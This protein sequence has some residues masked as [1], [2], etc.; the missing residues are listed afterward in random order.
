MTEIQ[1]DKETKIINISKDLGYGVL[2]I[3]AVF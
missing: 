1:L 2:H 3:R